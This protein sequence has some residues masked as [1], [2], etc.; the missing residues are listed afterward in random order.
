MTEVYKYC[1]LGLID[2]CIYTNDQ[3]K[4]WED[5]CINSN[6][7]YGVSAPFPIPYS[8]EKIDG[9]PVLTVDSSFQYDCMD[10]LRKE[11]NYDLCAAMEY[12]WASAVKISI[13]ASWLEIPY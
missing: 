11:H 2:A 3:P 9:I 10:A 1:P 7:C 6:Y 13:I 4:G 5:Y 12:G 8:Y